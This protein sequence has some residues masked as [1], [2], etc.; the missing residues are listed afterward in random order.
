MSKSE[1]DEVVRGLLSTFKRCKRLL[2]RE[3]CRLDDAVRSG[4]E[5]S[6]L[7][8][9]VRDLQE[10]DLVGALAETV[11][12]L[13][14]IMDDE[15]WTDWSAAYNEVAEEAEIVVEQA[16][17]EIS[18]RTARSSVALQKMQPQG[19]HDRHTHTDPSP[20]TTKLETHNSRTV[21]TT[22]L[23]SEFASAVK[24][25]ALSAAMSRL[26]VGHPSTFLGDTT[27]FLDRE[28]QFDLL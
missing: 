9:R 22:A 10:G 18:K 20:D 13:A 19:K 5:V 17:L 7:Q 11:N 8:K 12:A 27:Q 3:T 23:D 4:A 28:A 24:D 21:V 26:P 6:E 2:I 1:L 15:E 14:P 16:T 25:L